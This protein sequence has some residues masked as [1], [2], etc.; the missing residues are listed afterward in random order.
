MTYEIPPHISV[1]IEKDFSQRYGVRV[2]PIGEDAEAFVAIGHLSPQFA[3]Q[4]FNAEARSLGWQDLLDG[5]G[6]HQPQAWKEEG[7]GKVRQSWA[8]FKQHCDD[9]DEPGHDADCHECCE[10]A[11]YGWWIV[12]GCEPH[13]SDVFPVTVWQH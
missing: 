1:R 5:H 8:V 13:E 11:E 9:H 3:L 2:L 4:V 6:A 7:L 10:I 12:W